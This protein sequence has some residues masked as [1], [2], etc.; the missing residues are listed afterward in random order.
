MG[1]VPKCASFDC[2]GWSLVHHSS[3]HAK[4]SGVPYRT[5][6]GVGVKYFATNRTSTGIRLLGQPL[7]M[8]QC[9]CF[10]IVPILTVDQVSKLIGSQYTAKDLSDRY[11]REYLWQR[12]SEIFNIIYID[13]ELEDWSTIYRWS[14]YH[15]NDLYNKC[16]TCSMHVS[17][18][19]VMYRISIWSF[20]VVL[21]CLSRESLGRG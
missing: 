7:Y 15:H 6:P 20:C 8:D 9:F 16:R 13:C 3:C 21:F 10:L 18:S 1:S 11:R 2:C 5:V 4:Y 17:E 19:I 12:C 14:R